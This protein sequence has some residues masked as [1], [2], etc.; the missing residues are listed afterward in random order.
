[1][2]VVATARRPRLSVDRR[3]FLFFLFSLFLRYLY[4]FFASYF[5]HFSLNDQESAQQ[6]STERRKN[7]HFFFLFLP[8]FLHLINR[9][10]SSSI[11]PRI[12]VVHPPTG[13]YARC[14]CDHNFA[15]SCESTFIQHYSF[16]LFL[17]QVSVLT[18]DRR[19]SSLRTKL[20]I[21]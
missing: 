16:F 7:V 1:M 10:Q 21:F 5:L 15:L 20:I 6:N 2:N 17:V 14:M 18:V 4:F 9:H 19:N 12:V 13:C 3:R 11:V 8:P